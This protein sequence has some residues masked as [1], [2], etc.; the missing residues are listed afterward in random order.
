MQ[1]LE[2]AITVYEQW[3]AAGK[4]VTPAQLI[5]GNRDLG[6]LLQAM[7]ADR[8]EVDQA[9]AAADG[10][11]R[12]LGDFR[13]LGEIGRGGMGVVYRARQRSLDREVALKVL[14]SHVTLQPSAVARFRR[15]ATLAARLEHPNIVAIHAVGDDGDTNFFAMELVDGAPLDRIDPATGKPRSVRQCVE[16]C[17]AVADA[18]A[19]AHEHGV[20]HRDVKPTNILVRKDGRPVLTD[21]GL[22]R[23]VDQPGMTRTGAFAGTPHYTAPEQAAGSKHVDARADVWS[24]GATLYELL[25]G[26]RAFEG[27][28]V[29]DVIEQ[30]ARREPVDP[31]RLV[32][33]LSPDLAAIVLK[34][35]EKDPARRYHSARAFA[36]DLRAFLEFRPIAARRATPMRRL[37]RWIR[38]EPLRATLAAVLVVGGPALLGTL[39]YVWSNAAR[40]AAAVAAEASR[41]REETIARAWLAFHEEDAASGLRILE[42]LAGPADREL[43]VSR[44]WML[45]TPRK[46]EAHA[47]LAAWSD[48]TAALLRQFLDGALV[49]TAETP[50]GEADALDCFFRAQMLLEGA[51]RRG[52]RVVDV[53]R[54][55][56]DMVELAITLAP[57]PRLVYFLT[58]G[59]IA[60]QIDDAAMTEAAAVALARHFP[61]SPAAQRA[62]VGALG[63]SH[64][65]AALALIA[66]IRERDPAARGLLR[67]EGVALEALGKL[68]EAAA[69]NRKAVAEDPTDVLAFTN[70]G[71][72]LRKQKDYAGS[73]VALQ[74]AL[75]LRPQ[76]AQ[77][78]NAIGLTHRGNKNPAEARAAFEKALEVRPDYGAPAYNLGNLLVAEKDFT[79]A[80]A[81]FRRAVAAE[82]GDVRYVANLGD[83]LERAGQRQ[84][85]FVMH[86]RAA[87]LAPNDLIPNYNVAATA[88]E[89]GLAELALPAARRAREL[90]ETGFHGPRALAEA[91]LAQQQVDAPAALAA[92]REAEARAKGKNLR[93]RVVLAKALAASGERDE[94]LAMLTAAEQDPAL[95]DGGDR[96]FLAKTLADLRA[97]R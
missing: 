80:I 58:K 69:A 76:G 48:P 85:A 2:R 40:I 92:A 6:E 44:A 3:L 57:E 60:Q 1:Q 23:D 67:L 89:L 96:Q 36:D 53:L 45:G 12:V 74:Q 14:P 51:T 86:L 82:P 34:A 8:D 19:H 21:F 20:L 4:P 11:N 72:V 95:P 18:L 71:I 10:E 88:T 29:A 90:D 16:L 70:L 91:L 61:D 46:A 43:A 42:G 81:A 26:R 75:Q 79:G 5:D 83:A 84:E 63:K 22:A 73:L 68:D 52:A 78:W 33:A 27:D 35:L 77:I 97:A 65:E 25:T 93:V 59:T 64:P 39:A 49:R 37:Q 50:I 54:R 7:L 17:A 94:A 32:P 30:I 47:L 55:A 24:L 41:A 13:I 38:R 15:E 62:R 9:I 56:A 66:G 31:V 28:T 87:Q